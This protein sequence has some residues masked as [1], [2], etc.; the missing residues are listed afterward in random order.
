MGYQT[1]TV[2]PITHSQDN[3]G[4]ANDINT[5]INYTPEQF[6]AP[7]GAQITAGAIAK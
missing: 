5:P 2:G 1:G 6:C 7:P 4:N 3:S